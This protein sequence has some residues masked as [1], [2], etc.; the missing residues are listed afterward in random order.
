LDLSQ[1]FLL[2]ITKKKKK[3]KGN[4]L[5]LNSEVYS[6]S[7]TYC[8]TPQFT[9]KRKCHHLDEKQAIFNGMDVKPFTQDGGKFIFMGETNLPLL[10]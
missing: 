7:P 10:L 3:K 6:F 9:L 1:C 8:E 4:I 5:N 2:I